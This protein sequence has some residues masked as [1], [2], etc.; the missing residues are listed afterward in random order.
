[1]LEDRHISFV[2][3]ML[4]GSD[5]CQMKN[6]GGVCVCLTCLRFYLMKCCHL[7]NQTVIDIKVFFFFFKK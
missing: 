2:D 6:L 7:F 4:G 5:Y 3:K 1:V